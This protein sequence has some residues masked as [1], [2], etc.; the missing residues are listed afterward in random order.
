MSQGLFKCILCTKERSFLLGSFWISWCCWCEIHAPAG[1]AGMSG[2]WPSLPTWSSCVGSSERSRW[3]WSSNIS[4]NVNMLMIMWAC[5]LWHHRLLHLN[6][7]S[8][9]C[10]M[11]DFLWTKF[12]HFSQRVEMLSSCQLSSHQSMTTNYVPWYKWFVSMLVQETIIII[13]ISCVI[14]CLYLSQ[15][16]DRFT[17]DPISW[18]LSSSDVLRQST[19]E[20]HNL[21]TKP[22]MISIMFSRFISL[23]R[24]LRDL[25]NDFHGGL[26]VTYHDTVTGVEE[27]EKAHS[28]Q[29]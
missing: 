17:W 29:S 8:N 6:L 12:K 18:K 19:F 21:F 27:V 5:H 9:Q 2:H 15:F 3:R 7:F 11:F 4:Y 23:V 24:Y 28:S 16:S 26:A 14:K 13:I 22:V 25:H 1:T 10:R 20:F